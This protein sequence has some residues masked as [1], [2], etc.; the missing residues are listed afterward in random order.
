MGT[1][2]KILNV[3]GKLMKFGNFLGGVTKNRLFKI[4]YFWSYFFIEILGQALST[5]FF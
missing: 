5:K 4:A 2:L 3:I 1:K